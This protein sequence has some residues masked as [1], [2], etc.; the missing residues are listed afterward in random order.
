MIVIRSRPHK[1]NGGPPDSLYSLSQLGPLGGRPRR[2]TRR[3]VGWVAPQEADGGE[4]PATATSTAP[5]PP[6]S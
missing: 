2:V 1:A 4:F 3:V 5:A 6:S